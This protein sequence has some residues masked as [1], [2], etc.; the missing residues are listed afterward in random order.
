MISNITIIT[1]YLLQQNI[2]NKTR[3]NNIVVSIGSVCMILDQLILS[4][5]IQV[6]RGL[7]IISTNPCRK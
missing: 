5:T 4:G 1:V 6:R 3:R 2:Y 7:D